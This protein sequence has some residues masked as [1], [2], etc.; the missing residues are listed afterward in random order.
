MTND[1]VSLLVLQPGGW[2]LWPDGTSRTHWDQGSGPGFRT[3]VQDPGGRL[4]PVQLLRTF[5]VMIT[6][7]YFHD[8]GH[9]QG[10]DHPEDQDDHEDHEDPD[11][12]HDYDQG[13]DDHDHL[14]DLRDQ[15]HH[16]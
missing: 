3:R 6:V 10:H 12:H 16:C 7:I 14:H 9:D 2:N 15:C 4:T 11:D 13:H 1:S 8:Q 5:K